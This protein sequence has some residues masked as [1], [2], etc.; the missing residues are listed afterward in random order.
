MKGMSIWSMARTRLVSA[1]V[2]LI[3][4]GLAWAGLEEVTPELR[5]SVQGLAEAL[6]TF[7]FYTSTTLFRTYMEKRALER[8]EVV[9]SRVEKIT[10]E[11]R[12]QAGE[13]EGVA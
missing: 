7:V 11:L 4:A 5:E 9:P 12:E 2:G 8:G 13:G 6:V 3:V 1:L 10:P